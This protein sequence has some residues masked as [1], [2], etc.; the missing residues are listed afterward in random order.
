MLELN[1]ISRRCLIVIGERCFDNHDGRPLDEFTRGAISGSV[2]RRQTASISRSGSHFA[3]PDRAQ[4]RSL[5]S[6]SLSESGL[7]RLPLADMISS[8]RILPD[9]VWMLTR[10]APS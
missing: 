3:S 7:A 5:V 10:A 2:S 6:I 4:S 9:R 1:E 8:L